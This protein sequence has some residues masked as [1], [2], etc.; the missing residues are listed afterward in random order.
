MTL[1]VDNLPE[2]VDKARPNVR[3]ALARGRY[4]K[5]GGA[6]GRGLKYQGAR[7]G[8]RWGALTGPIGARAPSL[9]GARPGQAP[10][11]WNP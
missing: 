4:C 6:L 7:A 2:S 3:G 5:R 10:E 8:A 11:G 9:E 1:P